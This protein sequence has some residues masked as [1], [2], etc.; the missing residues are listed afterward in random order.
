[1]T[2]FS[3]K[4]SKILT[5]TFGKKFGLGVEKQFWPEF[6]LELKCILLFREFLS[7]GIQMV[8][9]LVEPNVSLI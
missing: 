9:L 3:S 7:D 1:M 6:N 5:K 2:I 4:K 8:G